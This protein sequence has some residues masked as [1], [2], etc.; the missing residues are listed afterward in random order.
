VATSPR[1]DE[2]LSFGSCSVLASY[3]KESGEQAAQPR[4]GVWKI[5]IDNVKAQKPSRR[6]YAALDVRRLYQRAECELLSG[7]DVEVVSNAFSN[8]ELRKN[9]AADMYRKQNCPFL[10]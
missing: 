4:P 6:T 5:F 7:Q 8:E 9:K 10:K 1:W 2:D 3:V